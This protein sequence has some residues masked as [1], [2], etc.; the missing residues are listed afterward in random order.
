MQTNFFVVAVEDGPNPKSTTP[1][2]VWKCTFNL[3]SSHALVSTTER[4]GCTLVSLKFVEEDKVF[5]WQVEM[6]GIFL[7][8]KMLNC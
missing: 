1:V 7:S 3:L 6:L 2:F 8:S 4:T 5:S